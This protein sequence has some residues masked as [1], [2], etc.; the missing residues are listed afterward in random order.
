MKDFTIKIP[1]EIVNLILR[2]HIETES[3]KKIILTLLREEEIE[4]TTERFQRYQTE[5][6]NRAF[7]FDALKKFINN[8]YVKPL[9]NNNDSVK[10]ELNYS[11]NLLH[12]IDLNGEDEE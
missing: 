1:E 11:D 12:I 5:Y 7:T 2:Y 4:V 8:E 3:R 6:E 10:W 9:L